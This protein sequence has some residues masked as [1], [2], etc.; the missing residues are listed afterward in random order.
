MY[1]TAGGI[2]LFKAGE[3]Y[4]IQGVAEVNNTFITPQQA[5]EI[6]SQE[7]NSIIQDSTVTVT[8]VSLEYCPT[9]YNDNYAQVKLIPVWSI[10]LNTQMPRGRVDYFK[11]MICV[12]VVTGDII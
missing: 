7:Y 6:A 10:T 11:Q 12:N 9:A 3:L 5:I 2:T 4:Q 8:E 1:L